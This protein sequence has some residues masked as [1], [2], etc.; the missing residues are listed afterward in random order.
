MY[1]WNTWSDEEP[2]TQEDID[3]EEC[4]GDEDYHSENEQC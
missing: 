4:Q 1:T 3:Q 2:K